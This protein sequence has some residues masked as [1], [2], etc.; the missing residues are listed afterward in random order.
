MLAHAQGLL[1]GTDSTG[2]RIIGQ[3]LMTVEEFINA[4]RSMFELHYPIASA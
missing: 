2:T 3:P 4:H 1:A